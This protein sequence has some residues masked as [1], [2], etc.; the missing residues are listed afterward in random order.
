MWGGFR[1]GDEDTE[2]DREPRIGVYTHSVFS[3][4]LTIPLLRS[5][6]SN[7]CGFLVLF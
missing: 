6:N 2:R 3:F 7:T 5:L 4:S 1:S